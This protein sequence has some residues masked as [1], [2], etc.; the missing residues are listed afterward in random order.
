MSWRTPVE[1][2]IISCPCLRSPCPRRYFSP[3]PA[4]DFETSRWK[5]C[6]SKKVQQKQTKPKSKRK[7]DIAK[8]A[9]SQCTNGLSAL[10]FGCVG[11]HLAHYLDKTLEA[12]SWFLLRFAFTFTCLRLWKVLVVD[13]CEMTCKYSE[14]IYFLPWLGLW[15]DLTWWRW[16][17]LHSLSLGFIHGS[18]GWW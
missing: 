12:K 3:G 18:W 15:L 17:G 2:K 5:K 1:S 14:F 11:W 13:K 6:A 8:H 4:W 16:R 10:A 9:I 7:P